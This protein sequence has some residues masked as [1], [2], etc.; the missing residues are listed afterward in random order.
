MCSVHTA[1]D[2]DLDLL[3]CSTY[4]AATPLP[5]PPALVPAS[6]TPPP[7]G[8]TAAQLTCLLPLPLLHP[9]ILPPPPPLCPWPPS[10]ATAAQLTHLNMDKSS[11]LAAAV[12]QRY[13][14]QHEGLLGE[15]QLAFVAFVFGQSLDG[16]AQWKGRWGWAGG[17]G[18]GGDI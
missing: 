5:P 15:M 18:V 14:G 13:G 3:S 4:L 10:G 11:V 16:F 12:Q 7:P 17:G 6:P 8:A 1:P 2:V 9:R